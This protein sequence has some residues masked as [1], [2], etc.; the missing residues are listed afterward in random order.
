MSIDRKIT[1]KVSVFPLGLGCMGLS[2]FYGQVDY[3]SSMDTIEQAINRGINFIDT[4]DMYGRGLSEELVGRV[5]NKFDR[6]KLII[7]TKVGFVRDT[8]DVMKMRLDGR[9]EHI[10][11]A[12]EASLKRLGIESID[13]YFLHRV[14]PDCPVEESIGA[15]KDLVQ[16]GK[17]RNIGLSDTT[18]EQIERGCTVHPVAA[19]QGEYSLWHRM[20]ETDGLI[21][22][23]EQ[24]GIVFMPYCPLGRGFLAGELED[25]DQ[26]I[27]EGDVRSD[28][29]RFYRENFARNLA[30]L[31]QLKRFCKRR[32]LSLAALALSWLLTKN[33]KIIPIVGMKQ[34]EQVAENLAA[35]TNVSLGMDDMLELDE[36]MPLN[37][38][39]GDAYPSDME[40]R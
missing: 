39:F 22:K 9:P 12:C 40:V 13:L 31:E 14:D 28:L 10:K 15:M 8:E 27:S 36:L 17:I 33:N 25:Y 2:E 34:P 24:E 35:V 1:D 11:A 37:C 29:P 26:L 5:I 3:K 18:F 4:A 7:S 32:N 38:A 20:P 30:L 6:E 23:C 16:A 21:D 19:Y